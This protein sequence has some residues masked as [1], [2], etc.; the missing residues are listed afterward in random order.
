LELQKIS[1]E[2][3]LEETGGVKTN[4]TNLNSKGTRDWEND[5]SGIREGEISGKKKDPS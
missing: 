4:I 3:F 2:I 5:A 1:K